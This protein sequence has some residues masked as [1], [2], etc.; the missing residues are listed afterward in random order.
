MLA[1]DS[2]FL[3]YAEKYD[4]HINKNAVGSMLIYCSI[5]VCAIHKDSVRKACLSVL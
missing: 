1:T 2:I 5:A 4:A 3:I